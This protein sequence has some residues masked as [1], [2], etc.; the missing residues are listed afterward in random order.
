MV[1]HAL[2]IGNHFQRRGNQAQ[3][4]CYRLL[5]QNQLDAQAFYIFFLLVDCLF[6]L[7]DLLHLVE[8]LV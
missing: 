3:I 1:A 5:M 6:I 2:H 8:L 4:L 7:F